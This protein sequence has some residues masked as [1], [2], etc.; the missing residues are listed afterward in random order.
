MSRA[1]S[2]HHLLTKKRKELRL[3]PV[4]AAS[5]GAPELG[6][7]WFVW[8][9]SGQGKTSF[10]LQL[11][12]VMCE[13][14]YRVLYNS[15]EEGDSKSFADAARRNG[16]DEYG[17]RFILVDETM[18][19]LRKR[20]KRPKSPEVVVTDSLQYSKM[21]YAEYTDF[22]TEF[23]NKML[24]FVS[25]AQGKEPKGAVADGARYDCSVKVWIEGFR[26]FPTS[27]YG[28]NEPLDIWPEGAARYYGD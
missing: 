27:R 21:T 6:T 2:V 24:V 7:G 8:G 23:K 15:R 9:Q 18:S 26:A 11:C 10:V 22:K 5:F 4:W 17:R 19:D 14:G 20:L 12:R 13:L 25:H 28:G 3:P 1:I 16:L